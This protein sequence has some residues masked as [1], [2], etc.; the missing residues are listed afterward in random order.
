MQFQID[1]MA[2]DGCVRSLTRAIRRLDAAAEVKADLATKQVT[3][4]SEKPQ[5]DIVA[6]LTDAGFPPVAA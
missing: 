5:A 2:C 1:N 6:A 3:V 4:A